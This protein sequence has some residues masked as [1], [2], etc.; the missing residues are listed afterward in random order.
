MKAEI[1]NVI[2]SQEAK[3]VAEIMAYVVLTT[4]TLSDDE[5]VVSADELVRSISERLKQIRNNKPTLNDAIKALIELIELI[6]TKK[7][8]LRWVLKMIKRFL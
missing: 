2:D 4:S 6:S 3:N 1:K 5:I 7:K 8:W